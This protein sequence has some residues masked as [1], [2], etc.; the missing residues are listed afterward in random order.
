MPAAAST[1]TASTGTEAKALRYLAEGRIRAVSV[2]AQARTATFRAIGSAETPYTVVYAQGFWSCTCPARV[3]DCA[4]VK[5]CALV[6]A[7]APAARP[8]SAART[9]TL[10]V[11][12]SSRRRTT[13]VGASA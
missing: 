5:A 9:R 11:R 10:P 3:A 7:P 8:V 12:Q 6:S 2:D 1:V 4:H 13:R